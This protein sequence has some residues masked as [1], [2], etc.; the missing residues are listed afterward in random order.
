MS[1]RFRTGDTEVELFIDSARLSQFCHAIFRI[2]GM[3]AV[4]IERIRPKMNPLGRSL[5]ALL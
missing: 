4:Y 5:A 1:G 2:R 3:G